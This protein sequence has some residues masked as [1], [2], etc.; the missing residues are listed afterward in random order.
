[1]RAP[2]FEASLHD[3]ALYPQIWRIALGILLTLFMWMG[4]TALILAGATAWVAAQEGAFGVLPF[5]NS[6]SVP[7]TPVKVVLILSTFSGLAAGAVVSAAALH[8]R[9]PGSLLGPWEDWRRGFFTAL[10]ALAV[11]YGGLTLLTFPLDPPVPNLPLGQ[12]LIWLPLALPFLFLQISAEEL[13]FRGY[14]QQQ[15]AAR[16]A[17]RVVWMWIPSVVFAVLHTSP[18]AGANLP[19]VLLAAFTFALVAADLT[20]RTGSLGAAMGLHFGNNFFGVFI[21]SSTGSITGLSLFQSQ[22]DIGQTGIQSLGMAG[23]VLL[24]LAVWAVTVR[25]L[26]E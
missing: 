11:A 15:L 7:D 22:T 2:I 20:E 1:M 23:A 19:L 4:A 24:M 21:T 10:A 13:F 12:W 14:L 5:L 26:D 3:A 6:L 8:F 16:F 9:G 17:S 18:Q 25:L